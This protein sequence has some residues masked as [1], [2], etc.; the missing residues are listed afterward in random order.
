[1]EAINLTKQDWDYIMS[2]ILQATLPKAGIVRTFPHSVLYA[3]KK[4]SGLGILHPFYHQH[5]KHIHTC[6]EQCITKSITKNLLHTNTEQLCLELGFNSHGY[7]H[8]PATKAYL[9]PSW[10][11]DLL[12]FCDD[13]S[14]QL[15]DNCATLSLRTTND[16]FLMQIFQCHYQ[17]D[18]L[19]LLHQ[20]CE[21]LQVLT[22]SDISTA[23]GSRIDPLML[24]G[25]SQLKPRHRYTWPNTPIQLSNQHW[26][27]WSQAV[28][29]HL[30]QPNLP[31]HR[32]CQPI[33]NWTDF[34]DW[35]WFFPLLNLV[36]INPRAYTTFSG[37]SYPHAHADND[38]NVARW[39]HTNPMIPFQQQS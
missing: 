6:L 31:Q 3:S 39:S 35:K 9:T 16:R 12:S 21:F 29:L 1:M 4:F 38:F 24:T 5:I 33:G 19:R 32:L 28:R 22:V 10:T 25:T 36:F 8:T 17:G 23:D 18:H 14:I 7:W 26:T 34:D 20:C 2:P 13:H 27:L 15:I 37:L 11:R 30:T